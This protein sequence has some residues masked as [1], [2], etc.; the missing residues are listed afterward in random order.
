MK[1]IATQN[2]GGAR[3]SPPAL[4]CGRLRTLAVILMVDYHHS[5]Y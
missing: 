1:K 5:V 2:P 4:A 3:A